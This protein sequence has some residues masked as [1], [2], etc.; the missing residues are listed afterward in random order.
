LSETLDDLDRDRKR[1][2]QCRIRQAQSLRDLWHL[3]PEVFNLISIER[4]QAEATRRLALLNRHFPVRAPR[5]S[6][7]LQGRI[8]EAQ[9]PRRR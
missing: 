2:L 1:D 9:A 5:S 3:R 8:A 4:D 6:M 7:P